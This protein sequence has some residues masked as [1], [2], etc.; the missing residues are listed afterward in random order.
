MSGIIS[1]ASPNLLA[2]FPSCPE[3]TRKPRVHSGDRSTHSDKRHLR[4]QSSRAFI[5]WP[6]KLCTNS[7]TRSTS[8]R[9]RFLK[10]TAVLG[11]DSVVTE[12]GRN[13]D[14]S[15]SVRV[16]RNQYRQHLTDESS[17]VFKGPEHELSFPAGLG[18]A[19]VSQVADEIKPLCR[20]ACFVT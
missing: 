1:G 10:A 7:C 14:H 17:R 13:L 2:H 16:I 12:T 19:E 5:F 20:S 8:P 9:G 6:Q 4:C 3:A 15:G 18:A 11:D